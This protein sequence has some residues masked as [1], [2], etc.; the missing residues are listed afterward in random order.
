MPSLIDELPL[1]ALAAARAR[2][3]TVVRGAEDLRKKESDRI[4]TVAEALTRRRC[5]RRGDRRRLAASAA[6][7]RASAAASSTRT[8]TTGSR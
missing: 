2:G 8:A 3:T 1:I 7:R 5:A 6:C 4:A